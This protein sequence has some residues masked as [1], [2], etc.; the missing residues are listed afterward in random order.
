MTRMPGI[1]ISWRADLVLSW[2]EHFVWN[3]GVVRSRPACPECMMRMS[4][5]LYCLLLG[6]GELIL[7]GRAVVMSQWTGV[8]FLAQ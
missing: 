2:K 8:N 3:Q 6:L 1:F 4:V 7:P 5:R